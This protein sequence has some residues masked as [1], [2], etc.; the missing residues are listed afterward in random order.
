MS[1][2]SGEKTR[3]NGM[4]TEARYNSFIKSLLRQGTRKWAPIQEVKRRA[5]VRRGV[6]RCECCKVEGPASIVVEGKRTNNAI[7]DHIETIIP[8]EEGFIDWD[9]TIEA[10]FSETDNL[11]LLC[12]ACHSKKTTGERGESAKWRSGR[13]DFYKEYN[14]WKSMIARC[15]HEHHHAYPL[16]GGRGISVDPRWEDFWTFLEDMPPR[17][18]GTTLDRLDNDKDYTPDN[19]RWATPQEQANNRSNNLLLELGGET[20]TLS[21][22]AER[23]DIP[24]STLSNRFARGDTTE[25]ALSKD[26]AKKTRPKILPYEDIFDDARKGMSWEELAAKYGCHRDTVRKYVQRRKKEESSN[27]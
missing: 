14:S 4:W 11:Q 23:L 25:R 13:K 20:L 24:V 3:C 5:R 8:V 17:P 26:Y 16:Y 19:C 27:D 18:E 1:R 9:E 2:P 6:Y 12:H 15:F 22:W 21:Q 7:V 10:M